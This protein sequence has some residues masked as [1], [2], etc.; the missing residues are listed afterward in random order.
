MYLDSD[1]VCC[2]DIAELY[3]TDIKNHLI[4]GVR[5]IPVIGLGMQAK[6]SMQAKHKLSHSALDVVGNINDYI[7][8]GVL[9]FNTGTFR[10]SISESKLLDMA[11]HG[12]YTYPDQDIINIV[13]KEKKVILSN[14]WNCMSCCGVISS[15]LSFVPDNI[16]QDYENTETFPNI[17]HFIKKPWK[18]PFVLPY[19]DHFWKYATK[20]AYIDKIM[21]KMSD[22]DILFCRIDFNDYIL[23]NI[24]HRKGISLKF[25]LRCILQWITRDKKIK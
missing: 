10:K 25:L 23:D 19:S 17:I 11:M 3:K 16:K 22:S 15:V 12:E 9:L 13:C 5:D 18:E 8:T 24:K 7:N 1:T 14:M 6:H 21:K 20:T 2:T 4:A